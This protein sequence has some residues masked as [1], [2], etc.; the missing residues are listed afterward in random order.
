MREELPQHS[1]EELFGKLATK[2]GIANVLSMYPVAITRD[3]S[4]EQFDEANNLWM[5]QVISKHC[6]TGPVN[7]FLK[8]FLP[9][10]A[11]CKAKTSVE[12]ILLK[13]NIYLNVLRRLW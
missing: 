10:I 2:L 1:F 3:P 8:N 4:D 5:L 9:V 6:E 11:Q 13:R 7:V 12:K